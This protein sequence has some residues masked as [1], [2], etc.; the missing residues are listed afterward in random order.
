MTAA[1][2]R[3]TWLDVAKGLAIVLV[4]WGH[5]VARDYRPAG[6]DWYAW[7]NARLYTFHMACFFFLAGLVYHLRPPLDWRE[8]WLRTAQ[9]LVPAYVL[10]GGLVFTGKLVAVHWLRVDRPV[11]APL[12]ELWLQLNYPTQGFASFL[13]FIVVLLQLQAAAP[14]LTGLCRGHVWP[15]LAM[16]LALHVLSVAGFITEWAAL[17]QLCRYLVFFQLGAVLVP[18]RQSVEAWV[19]RMW[20]LL[21]PLFVAALVTFPLAWLPTL[22]AALS[23]PV[24]VG[25]ARWV[26]QFRVADGFAALG[27]ASFSI[28]LMNSLFLGL[29]R[30]GVQRSFGWDD[31]RFPI[32]AFALLLLG[33]LGPMLLQ[34]H[35]LR[36]WQPLDRI[37]R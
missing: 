34:R 16:G 19:D 4:V 11:G 30:A 32:V 20:P 27:L 3:E 12:A 7:T 5:V 17:H 21:L 23:L 8:R 31:W 13:W 2:V 15:T 18:N 28:Y 33:L 14:L 6:N 35:V 10:F 36:R 37:T 25:L 26:Q 9:R 29:G 1:A 22:G 24:L